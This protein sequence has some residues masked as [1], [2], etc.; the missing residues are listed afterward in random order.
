MSLIAKIQRDQLE[1]RDEIKEALKV[2]DKDGKGVLNKDQVEYMIKNVGEEL[3][4]AEVMQILDS[5]K[6]DL[7]GNIDLEKLLDI[8]FDL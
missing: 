1:D 4:E 3:S 6:Y 5:I 8:I 7:Q 2:F